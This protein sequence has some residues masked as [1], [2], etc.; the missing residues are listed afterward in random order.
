MVHRTLIVL[1]DLKFRL[2]SLRTDFDSDR[3]R[4]ETG[5]LFDRAACTAKIRQCARLDGPCDSQRPSG[6]ATLTKVFAQRKREQRST[7]GD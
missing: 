5:R 6:A 3:W 2:R 1:R 4:A 7:A